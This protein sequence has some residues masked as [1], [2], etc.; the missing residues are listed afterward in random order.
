MTILYRRSCETFSMVA[1]S[2]NA[3][4]PMQQTVSCQDSR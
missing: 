4:N 2:G 1:V 3:A